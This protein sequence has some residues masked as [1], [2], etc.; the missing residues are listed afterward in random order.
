MRDNLVWV[1]RYRPN[2]IEDCILPEHIKDKFRAIVKAGDLQNNLLLSGGPGCGKTTVARALAAELKA[3]CYLINASEKGNIDTLRTEIRQF[4][5]T[6]SLIGNG[7]KIVILDEADF[8]NPQSTQ[9]ALRGFMEEFS[10]NC[11]FILTCNLKNRVIEAI[12]SRCSVIDFRIPKTDIAKLA[13]QLFK[14]IK[15]IL[16]TE[17]VEYNE[18]VLP[19]L[20]KKHFPDFRRILNELQAYSVSGKIDEGILNN[21]GEVKINELIKAMKDKDFDK[22]RKWTVESIDNDPTRIM[23]SIYDAAYTQMEDN[24]IPVAILKIGEY[25]YRSGFV[26]DQEINLM[27]LI[28]ELMVEVE[29]KA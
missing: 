2:T 20:I 8:L 3:D 26:A 24:S 21:L 7:R 14:R 4:A 28:V 25:M 1:E 15:V 18:K 22:V 5:S 9:P 11:G 17:G 13:A 29:W 19:P 6:V 16:E 10:R 27:A 12:H 23:R